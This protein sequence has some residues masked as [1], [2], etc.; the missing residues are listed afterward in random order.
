MVAHGAIGAQCRRKALVAM[1]P[2]IGAALLPKCPLCLLAIAS[3]IGVELSFLGASLL[4]LLAIAVSVSLTLIVRGARRTGHT[5]GAAVACVAAPMVI[6]QRLFSL[7]SMLGHAAVAVLI[8][9]AFV[10]AWPSAH[11]ER[12]QG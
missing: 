9:A 10:T 8:V 7:P 3:T 5:A 11:C 4:P 12:A 6:A 2:A 1:L